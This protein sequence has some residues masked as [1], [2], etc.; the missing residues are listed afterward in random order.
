MKKE[1]IKIEVDAHDPTLIYVNGK[2]YTSTQIKT[3]KIDGIV[4]VDKVLFNELNEE[5]YSKDLNLIVNT[6]KEKTTSEELLTEIM[7]DVSP[8]IIKRIAKRIRDKKP[9]KKHH[10]CLGFKIGDSYIQIAGGI[11]I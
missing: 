9:I 11:D 5:Q 4:H 10:G 1:K 7:K 3:K 8:R 6:L 2:K